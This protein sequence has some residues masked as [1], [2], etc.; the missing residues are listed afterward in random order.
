[1]LPGCRRGN[2]DKVRVFAI[3]VLNMASLTARLKALVS[4]LQALHHNLLSV[5]VRSSNSQSI[6][7]SSKPAIVIS[8]HQDDETLG[9]GGLIALKRKAGVS[10]TVVFLTDGGGAPIPAGLNQQG[11]LKARRQEATIAL[12]KL[13]VAATQIHF[14][15][16][17]D[18]KLSHLSL[19]DRQ[20]LVQ[21]LVELCDRAEEVYVPH[22]K[23]GHP[24]H[25]AAY[26]LTQ[27]AIAQLDRAIDFYQYPVWIFWRRPLF[28]KLK[29]SDLTG[30][31]RLDIRSVQAQKKSAI[32]VYQ[33]QI[34]EMPKGFITP[35]FASSELF[36]KQNDSSS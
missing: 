28:W 22:S 17:P 34:P 16:Y 15:D 9:C 3:A 4:P 12:E 26:E 36:F 31:Y 27:S 21:K 19:D 24:D 5:W 20:A 32:E 1:M 2:S 25:E 6:E 29:P 11:L 33:S 8:P 10:V 13:R 30:C 7:V 18:A 35:F 14:L 23:D